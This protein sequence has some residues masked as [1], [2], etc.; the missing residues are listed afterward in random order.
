MIWV[1]SS[2]AVAPRPALTT[3]FSV[4]G[5]MQDSS[6]VAMYFWLLWSRDQVFDGG[7]FDEYFPLSLPHV[8]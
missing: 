8:E 3:V 4:F 5:D 2:I 6:R 7:Q 1:T